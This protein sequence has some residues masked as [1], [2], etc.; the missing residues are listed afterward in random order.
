MIENNTSL[1]VIPLSKVGENGFFQTLKPIYKVESSYCHYL[2]MVKLRKNKRN[3]LYFFFARRDVQ[4]LTCLTA[5]FQENLIEPLREISWRSYGI[6]YIYCDLNN[7]TLDCFIYFYYYYVVNVFGL[8]LH[9]HQKVKL[10]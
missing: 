3:D 8:I 5:K 9:S 2:E 7:N 6:R 10:S 1:A 4:K